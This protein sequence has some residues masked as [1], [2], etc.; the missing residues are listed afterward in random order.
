MSFNEVSHRWEL[1][2]APGL[3]LQ[4]SSKPFL[5]SKTEPKWPPGLQIYQIR[6]EPV[7]GTYQNAKKSFT[8][9]VSLRFLTPKKHAKLIY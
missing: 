4:I 2:K 6:W 3:S 5:T 7:Q 1:P 8:T 9:P